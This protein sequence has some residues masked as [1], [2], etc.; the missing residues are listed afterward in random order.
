MQIKITKNNLI[1]CGESLLITQMSNK[2]RFLL[3][4]V[5]NLDSRLV[6]DLS[7]E[8]NTAELFEH[9]IKQSISDKEKETNWLYNKRLI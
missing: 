1:C 3:T 9:K 4:C 6:K 8:C 7:M 2:F 5:F